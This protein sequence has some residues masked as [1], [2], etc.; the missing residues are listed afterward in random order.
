M[1]NLIKN[2]FVKIF[3]KK[4]TYIMFAF[5]FIFVVITNIIYK[6]ELDENGNYRVDYYDSGY[7]E[8]AKEE[9][10]NIKDDKEYE[11]S[12]RKDIMKYELIEKYGNESWQ[13]YII[14]NNM[15]NIIDGIVNCKYKEEN[16]ELLKMYE[17]EYN[18]Y[19][20]KFDSND[21]KYFVNLEIEDVNKRKEE[22]KNNSIYP[23]G[24]KE[25][26]DIQ[27][28]L[29]L[30]VLNYRLENNVDYSNTYLNSS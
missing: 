24:L 22:L 26:M 6:N 18:L 27:Y 30:E 23:S 4:S 8:F 3:N 25:D 19:I 21:Y 20:E 1:I 2:E 7:L 17:N 11:L 15:F 10:K 14:E 16:S 5:I 13:A 28:D 29:E 9:L 12:L